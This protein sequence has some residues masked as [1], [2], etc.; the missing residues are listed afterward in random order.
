ME[1]ITPLQKLA[2]DWVE[3]LALEELNM[4]ESGVVHMNE[5]LDPIHFLEESSIE[6][7][8]QLRERCEIYTMKFNEFR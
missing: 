3:Q 5:H 2:T 7:M 4:E 8:N 1:T 6:F